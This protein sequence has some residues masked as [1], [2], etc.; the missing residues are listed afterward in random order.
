MD[1]ADFKGPVGIIGVRGRMGELFARFFEEAGYEVMGAASSGSPSAQEVAAACR[2]VILS[3]QIP[4]TVGLIKQ[5]GPHTRQDGVLIDLTSVKQ[6]PVEAMLKHARGQVIGSHPLFGPTVPSLK[7]QVFFTHP[8]RGQSW[9]RW[10]KGFLADRQAK[11]IEISPQDHDRLM[12]QVQTLRHLMLTCMASC[13]METGFKLEEHFEV[14]GPWFR[15]LMA[16]LAQQYEQ[17]AE[18]Y[19][20]IALSN[21]G[22]KEVMDS[23]AGNIKHVTEMLNNKDRDG[24]VK[25]MDRVIAYLGEE[26][27]SSLDLAKEIRYSLPRP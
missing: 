15:I 12:A 16:V 5:I 9:Y 24:L 19:A 25:Y 14:A 17:P 13:L 18:L 6:G 27:S 7:N 1:E 2:V 3:V 26:F 23:F 22:S 10:F 11:L 21:P 8:S 4:K 20:D